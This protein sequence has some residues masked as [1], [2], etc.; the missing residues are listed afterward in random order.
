MRTPFRFLLAGLL[1][2][3][4]LPGLA[5]AAQNNNDEA[6]LGGLPRFQRALRHLETAHAYLMIATER[7]ASELREGARQAA[8]EVD[9]AINWINGVLD[10]RNV[11]R[12][13]SRGQ[14]DPG[15][16]D[17]PI[18]SAR[19]SLELARTQ[20]DMVNEKYDAHARPPRAR[21]RQALETLEQANLKRERALKRKNNK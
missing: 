21:I 16:R 17:Q 7:S 11:G 1:A 13:S 3:A 15:K 20:L 2:V 14:T 12:E 10:K 5:T 6:E 18:P 4:L 9:T 8:E 19:E